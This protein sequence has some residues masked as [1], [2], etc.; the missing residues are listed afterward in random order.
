MND[1]SIIFEIKKKMKKYKFNIISSIYLY[2]L[3]KNIKNV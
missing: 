2:K 1:L 3:F